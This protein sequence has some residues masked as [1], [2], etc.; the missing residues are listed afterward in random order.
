MYFLP[1]N[2]TTIIKYLNHRNSKTYLNKK[3]TCTLPIA[4]FLI[5]CGFRVFL[6]NKMRMNGIRN[7]E[8]FN[9]VLECGLIVVIPSCWYSF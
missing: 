4:G 8:K 5:G 3:F 7:V 9:N 2:S 6:Q 1:H